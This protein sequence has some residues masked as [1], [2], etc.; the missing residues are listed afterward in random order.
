[1]NRNRIISFKLLAATLL[2]TIG[3]TAQKQSKT[4]KETF[5]VGDDTVLEINTTHTDIEFETWDKNQVEITA[6]VELEGASDEEADKYFDRPPIEIKGNSREIEISTHGRNSWVTSFS[7]EDFNFVVPDVEPLFLDLQIPE[8]LELPELAVIPEMPPIPPMPPMPFSDF[9]YEQYRKDGDKYLKKW[10]KEFDKNFDEEY[11]ARF[12]EWGEEMKHRSEEMKQQLQERKEERERA[13]QEMKV[14]REE[15]RQVLKEQRA[16][17]QEQRQALREKIREE[18]RTFT[19]SG[20]G[21]EPNIFYFSSDGEHKKYKVKK[22]IKVKM[23]KSVKL[24]MNVR[25]GEVKLASTTKNI[26]ASLQ[27]ASLL[28]STIDGDQTYIKASYTPVM[29]EKWRFGDLKTDYA[30]LVSLKEV[31]NLELVST[32]SSITIDKVNGKAYIT[33]NLGDLVIKSIANGFS[34]VNVTVK[35]GEF[36][37]NL[38]KTAV[39][40]HLDGTL[41][42]ISYPSELKMNRTETSNMVIHEGY[43]LKP[44]SDKTITVNSKYSEVVL[45]D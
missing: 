28:A 32:S 38:P 43:L 9:D 6:V 29:V 22:T 41:S 21:E 8:L 25:H 27:Y 36:S 45:K 40:L 39:S 1:M 34:D 18:R 23:P 33:N 11:R 4:Y 35:N 5:N 31:D 14:A 13:L 19:I 20:D 17:M 44:N 2:A 42:S 10:K 3:L 24:K 16:A 30:E 7:T 12:E 26:N 15:Q 37:C